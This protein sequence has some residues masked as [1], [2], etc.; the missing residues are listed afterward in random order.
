MLIN[1]QE[2]EISLEEAIRREAIELGLD[3][4]DYFGQIE[5]RGD[6]G[7]YETLYRYQSEIDSDTDS[8]PE[9]NH[10]SNHIVF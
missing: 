8:R 7:Y 2:T 1:I 5:A 3:E 6:L 9:V 4:L 10:Y